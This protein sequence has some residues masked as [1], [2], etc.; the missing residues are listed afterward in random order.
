MWDGIPTGGLQKSCVLHW[1]HWNWCRHE[2]DHEPYGRPGCAEQRKVDWG[3]KNICQFVWLNPQ[4]VLFCDWLQTLLPLWCCQAV[5][6]AL[7]PHPQRVC[8]RITWQRSSPWASVETR[9]PKH[10]APRLESN[11]LDFLGLS[12][13]KRRHTLKWSCSCQA[14]RFQIYSL[15]ECNIYLN[16]AGFVAKCLPCDW[17]ILSSI[18]SPVTV[19]MQPQ[20]NSNHSV[21]VHSG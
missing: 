11:S 14:L 17:K 6:L 8:Q 1:Q 19:E 18:L 10:F 5:A 15:A 4:I 13:G 2:L 21:C 20:G 16:S 12:T 9:Q 7:E 3:K